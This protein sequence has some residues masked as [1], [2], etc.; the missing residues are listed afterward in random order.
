MVKKNLFFLW[1]IIL[2]FILS[3]NLSF[4]GDYKIHPNGGGLVSND[5]HVPSSVYISSEI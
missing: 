3:I 4:S 2:N 5:S 1:V